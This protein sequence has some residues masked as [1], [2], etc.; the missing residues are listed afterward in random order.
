MGRTKS[1]FRSSTLF[2]DSGLIADYQF[3]QA[4][5]GFATMRVVP[6]SRATSADLERILADIR[7]RVEGVLGFCRWKLSMRSPREGQESANV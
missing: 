5:P 7:R 1:E 3:V 6:Y 4:A 2:H